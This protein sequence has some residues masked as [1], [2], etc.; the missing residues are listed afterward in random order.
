LA[1]VLVGLGLGRKWRAALRAVSRQPMRL[2][3]AGR[4]SQS[5][6]LHVL[7]ALRSARL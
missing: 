5:S 1:D 6:Q 7:G 4:A 3:A 2:G